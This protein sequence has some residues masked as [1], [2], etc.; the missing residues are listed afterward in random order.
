MHPRVDNSEENVADENVE[1]VPDQGVQCGVTE[2]L[3]EN[4]EYTQ[5]GEATE[6]VI[7][8]NPPRTKKKTVHLQDFET[9]DTE[10][11]LHT[12]MDS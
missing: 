7:R 2:T 8:R 10:D 12:C 3:P 11:K 1:N 9:E 4:S 5:P 6:T